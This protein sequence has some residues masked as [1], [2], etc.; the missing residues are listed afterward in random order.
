MQGSYQVKIEGDKR[1]SVPKSDATIE[2]RFS[3]VTISSHQYIDKCL[4]EKINLFAIEAKEVGE[5]IE[6]PIH[7]KQF[8]SCQGLSFYIFDFLSCNAVIGKTKRGIFN[9]L[10]FRF[11]ENL[12]V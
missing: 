5:D 6:N 4:P 1:R 10:H 9:K 11:I 8:E 12:S 2:V 7:F 3:P